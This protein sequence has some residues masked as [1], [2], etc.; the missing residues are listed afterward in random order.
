MTKEELRDY[1]RTQKR[2]YTLEY[3][4]ECSNSII[5]R[6]EQHELFIKSKTILLYYS[7]SDEVNTHELL[8]KWQDKKQLL[9][10]AIINTTN[11]EIRS[12]SNIDNLRN[13]AFGICEPI[14]KAYTN[15][16]KIDLAIIPGMA[17]DKYGH[18]LGRGKGFYDRFLNNLRSY[19]IPLL[20]ICF[21]FQK[22]N[23]VPTNNWDIN[24]DEIL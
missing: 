22:V 21:D 12:Y 2:S 10:P 18:R 14:G 17:F 13:G 1:I 16:K 24:M 4:Q 23:Y 20:G 7:L 3:L 8:Q 11:L 6:L 15:Y 9:L 5:H 19:N